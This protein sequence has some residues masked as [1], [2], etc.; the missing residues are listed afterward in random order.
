MMRSGKMLFLTGMLVG[1]G[2]FVG[3][4]RAAFLVQVTATLN[5]PNANTSTTQFGQSAVTLSTF[6]SAPTD[7]NLGGTI[8][9]VH[10]TFGSTATQTANATGSDAVNLVYGWTLTLA[11]IVNG[12]TVGGTATVNVTG[13]IIGNL[14]TTGSSLDNM[15]LGG[16][17]KTP[18]IVKVDGVS[19]AVQLDAWTPPGT[20]P[21]A[22][23]NF[24]V[25]L[26][27]PTN[28]PINPVPEPTT[29][30]LMGLGGLLLL[31]P[32]IRRGFRAD[33]S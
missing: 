25:S 10:K 12:A 9:P 8:S 13:Q 29:V 22:A 14:S 11:H 5:G 16:P 24:S 27:D 7:I 18:T 15:Y 1:L 31:A 3:E 21:S 4:A 19:V 2:L 17:T 28:P 26:V 30:V 6:Q 20:P 23:Q 32:R 33:R